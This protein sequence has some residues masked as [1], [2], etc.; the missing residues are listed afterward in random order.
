MSDTSSS[1]RHTCVAT[2]RP[3][4]RAD[5]GAAWLCVLSSPKPHRHAGAVTASLYS[6]DSLILHRHL[7]ETRIGVV[8]V[9]LTFHHQKY[10]TLL[11]VLN[12][13]PLQAGMGKT[14]GRS[15][16]DEWRLAG[17]R[18]SLSTVKVRHYAVTPPLNSS[19]PT[20]TLEF[21]ARTRSS[22]NQ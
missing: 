15:K 17:V 21:V 1:S 6:A 10:K 5:Q 11:H 13:K 4:D 12:F 16:R 19:P 2:Q 3:H 9:I 7:V 14:S 18:V 20:P 8:I 22:Q